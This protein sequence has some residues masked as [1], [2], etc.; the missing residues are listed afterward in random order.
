MLK[1]EVELSIKDPTDENYAKTVLTVT[2]NYYQP[3]TLY[4]SAMYFRHKVKTDD[5]DNIELSPAFPKNF[6]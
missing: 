1:H 5:D 4:S 3:K 6:K 2:L